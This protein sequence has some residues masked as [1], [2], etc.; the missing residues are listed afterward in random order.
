M[1]TFSVIGIRDIDSVETLQLKLRG[2]KHI[3]LLGNGGIANEL[4]C[5]IENCKVTWIIKD[6]YINST[7]LDPG[8][9]Q[10]LMSHLDDRETKSRQ[11]YV[12][13]WQYET[14]H[15]S[16]KSSV[17]KMENGPALGP[18]WHKNLLL[19][20]MAE[21][22]NIDIQY[23]TTIKDI[24]EIPESTDTENYF[25]KLKITLANDKEV[26]CDFLVCATGVTPSVTRIFQKQNVKIAS[27]GGVLV[28]EAF[29]TSIKDIFAAGDCCTPSWEFSPFWVHMRLWT[30]AKQMG[31]CVAR[32]IVSS[33]K[34]E[35]KIPLDICFDVFTHVTTFFGFKVI[36]LGNFNAKNLNKDQCEILLRYTKGGEYIKIILHQNKMSGAT[37]VGETDYEETFEN[38]I[39]NQFDL[40]F[41]KENLLDPDVDIEDYFD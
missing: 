21:S 1:I 6:S 34:E 25:P 14:N 19:N 28:D 26:I 4:V 29:E 9:S 3:A 5:E 17:S 39:M 13:R 35:P 2:A 7:F 15:F 38:L 16:Q 23:S 31:T 36:L 8:A 24:H 32:S 27:D 10:F 33:L 30:Q 37:L 12:K 41:I 22:R 18:D 20:G 11:K 40:E